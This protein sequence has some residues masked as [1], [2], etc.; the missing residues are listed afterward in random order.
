MSVAKKV[1]R[2]NDADELRLPPSLPFP[3]S[4][5]PL[6]PLLLVLFPWSLDVELDGGD[7]VDE[8]VKGGIEED[9]TDNVEVEPPVVLV[10]EADMIEQR[11][12]L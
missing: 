5:N 9:V 7:H 4:P 3:L 6:P 12:E 11:Q 2:Y 1:Y 10:E 8:G